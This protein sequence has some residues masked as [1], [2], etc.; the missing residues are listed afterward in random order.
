MPRPTNI[1]QY[2]PQFMKLAASFERHP[3]KE[4]PIPADN[5]KA[6][7]LELQAFRA[8]LGQSA[9][10]DRYPNFLLAEIRLGGDKKSVI[11]VAKNRTASALAIQKAL[12]NLNHNDNQKGK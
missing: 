7:Q 6:V 9:E 12:S 10:K 2:P 4:I 11:V 1:K 3:T 8:A 5:P